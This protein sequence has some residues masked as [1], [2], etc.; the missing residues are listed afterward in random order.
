MSNYGPTQEV[1]ER[2][3]NGFTKGLL[4]HSF[5]LHSSS[6]ENTTQQHTH[7]GYNA[8]FGRILLMHD[9]LP[10]DYYNSITE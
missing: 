5:P 8:V 7:I 10:T 3:N 4:S 6:A 2:G 9:S 1:K